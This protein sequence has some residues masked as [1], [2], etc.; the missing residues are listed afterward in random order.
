MIEALRRP[1][2]YPHP[3][4]EPVEVLETHASW[5]ALAGDRAYKLKKP[6]DLGFLDFSTLERR[7]H[8]C[9]EE[10]RL[11]RRL[12]PAMYEAVVPVLGP[13]ERARIG[14]P[15]E[16][17]APGEPGETADAIEYAVRMRRFP[18]D[19]LLSEVARRG[20]LAG[21]A[22]DALA[23]RVARFHAEV[24]VAPAGSRF[25]TP[26]AVWSAVDDTLAL[27]CGHPHAP[28]MQERLSALR[29][30][31]EAERARLAPVFAERLAQGFV[32]ECHGDMHLGN[33]I[34][35]GDE[36]VVFDGI[37]FA[38]ELRWI[39]TASEIAFTEMDLLR[40]DQR[41]LAHRF[42]NAWC[43]ASGDYGALRVLPFYATYRALVRAK[44]DEIR[45]DQSARGAGEAGD[46]GAVREL[47]RDFAGYV[48]LAEALAAPR[49]PTLA[50]TYGLSGS[51]KTTGTTPLVEERGAV[52]VRSDVERKRLHG[53]DALARTGAAPGSGIY[54]ADASAR[55][56][57][58]LREL[59][60][61]ALAAG[62]DAIVDATFLARAERAPFRALARELGVPFEILVFEADE[63]V[64]R[65]RVAARAERA[66]DASEATVDVLEAQIARAEPPRADEAD[67]VTRVAPAP[68]R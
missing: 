41:A 33:M 12:A 53:L 68:R 8:F 7:L 59:A 27:L 30:W 58:R 61:V 48:A 39:D 19:R 45:R 18:Q 28:R 20:E 52:R 38:P 57:A 13:P 14:K 63:A 24:E 5:I 67:R 34:L 31:C 25:G 51:G 54:G 65:A 46:A 1:E 15:G 26:E 66:D 35:E 40:R 23:A 16:P 62:R 60:G 55:T 64:L 50:I 9:R 36:V 37:E 17:G 44:V 47:E 32:R 21:G 22:V 2:A 4:R 3:V 56:Y 6:V 29:A 49:A 10:L 42:V 43:E 11:N